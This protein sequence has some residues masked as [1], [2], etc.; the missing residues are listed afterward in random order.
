MEVIKNNRGG[1]KIVLD[2]YITLYTKKASKSTRIRWECSQ[3][4]AL[5]CKGALTTD[6]EVI[7]QPNTCKDKK[8]HGILIFTIKCSKCNNFNYKLF[9]NML[10]QHIKILSM[11]FFR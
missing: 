8:F 1:V 3:R 2:G 6:L 7:S 10:H 9:I 11:Y 5:Q 4:S